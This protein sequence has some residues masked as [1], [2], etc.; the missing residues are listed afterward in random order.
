MDCAYIKYAEYFIDFSTFISP[1]K[2]TTPRKSFF[3]QRQYI[4]TADIFSE[5]QQQPFE[6]HKRT[7]ATP[8]RHSSTKLYRYCTANCR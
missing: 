8:Y 2:L 7:S 6:S 5:S 3:I 4:E 1:I